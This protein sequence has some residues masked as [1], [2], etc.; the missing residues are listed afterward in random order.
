MCLVTYTSGSPKSA[1][2][3]AGYDILVFKELDRDR[4]NWDAKRKRY[5]TRLTSP[6]QSHDYVLGR[7]Y[8]VEKFGLRGLM[9]GGAC[10]V[11]EGLHVHTKVSKNMIFDESMFPAIIPKGTLFIPSPNEQLVALRLVVRGWRWYK[12]LGELPKR[13]NFDLHERVCSLQHYWEHGL[14]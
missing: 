4:W 14:P 6:Y 12:S 7:T 9:A 1:I 10:A 2:F 3:R 8:R 11:D 5:F 13:G